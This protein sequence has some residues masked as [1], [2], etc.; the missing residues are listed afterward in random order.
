MPPIVAQRAPTTSDTGYSPG[1][2]WVDQSTG[3]LY[4]LSAVSGG[5]ADWEILGGSGSDI[6][7]LTGDSGGAISPSNGNI[8]LAGGTGIST[9]GSTSTITF[10]ITGGAF[11][12]TEVTGTS[13]TMAINTGYIANNAA[14]VTL[15]LPSTAARGSAIAV[16]GKG[17]GGWQIAQNAG[18][19]I[20]QNST[21]TTTG[22]GGS[23]ASSAQYNCAY[24]VCIT[25]DIGWV[26]YG[27][28]GILTSV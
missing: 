9:V 8:T 4:G 14:L 19:T 11:E 5:A 21:S 27:S 16:V 20:Y 17:A 26:I 3:T 6:T 7:T 12:F 23:V 18:Q 28:Q 10:N 1:Q 24:L 13:Q 15:T 25:A 2:I 22:T